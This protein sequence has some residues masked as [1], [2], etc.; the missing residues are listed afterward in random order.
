MKLS[1]GIQVKSL[2]SKADISIFYQFVIFAI[3][4]AEKQRK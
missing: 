2:N 4:A 1:S 3:K